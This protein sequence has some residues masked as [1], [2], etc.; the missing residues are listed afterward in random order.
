[1]KTNL[2]DGVGSLIGADF[3]VNT[4]IAHKRHGH[5]DIGL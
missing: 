3:D 1:M 5:V 4:E 2:G